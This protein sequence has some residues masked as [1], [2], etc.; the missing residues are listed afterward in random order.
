MSDDKQILKFTSEALA[1]LRAE[2]AKALEVVADD[3]SVRFS[4]G[5]IRYGE[6][7]CRM[8]VECF[9]E[10]AA[11]ALQETEQIQWNRDCHSV[12]LLPSHFNEVFV[13]PNGTY[14]LCAIKRRN[15][16]YPLVAEKLNSIGKPTGKRFKFARDY[17]T[18]LL[19]K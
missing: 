18:Q 8:Q 3:L 17:V 9:V 19:S 5:N 6:M 4:I 14:K 2:V 16:K 15:H 10:T 7:S 1:T 12:G 13:T 11:T